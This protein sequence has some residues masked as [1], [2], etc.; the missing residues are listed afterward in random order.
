MRLSTVQHGALVEVIADGRLDESWADH[1]ASALDQAIRDGNH[2]IR[3]NMESVTYLSSAGIRVLVGC[4]NNVKQINGSFAV[5]N[6]SRQVRTILDMTLLSPM[7]IAEEPLTAPVAA[8]HEP[9]TISTENAAFELLETQRENTLVC[10]AVGDAARF[11]RGGF[12]PG[13]MS[14]LAFPADTFGL[15]VGAFGSSYADCRDRFGEFIA[16]AGTAAYLPTD[17]ASAPDYLVAAGSLVPEVGVLYGLRCDGSFAHHLRFEAAKQARDIGLA[18]LVS[19]C[20]LA[21]EAGIAG[22]VI[23]GET[24]GLVGA[25]LRRSPAS[26]RSTGDSPF[27]YPQIRKWLTFT[28]EPAHTRSLCLIVGVAC[29]LASAPAALG[30]LLRPLSHNGN[31]TAGHFHAAA[32]PYRPLQK[33]K[34]DLQ[35]TVQRMFETQGPQGL[36]HLL[37][38]DREAF[39]AGESRFVRGA[40]WIAPIRDV[41]GGEL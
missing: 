23:L 7:L 31:K 1:L 28:A 17:G 13:D 12:G 32:F 25:A 29:N 21:A 41:R 5:K 34:L 40:C 3:L 35:A 4:Y 8:G 6:P 20:M 19:A 30:P 9:V 39:G 15:G 38:D 11:E 10:H 33:G 26:E 16:A 18:E 2:H 22:M 24:T 14:T 36:L 37:P 27:A